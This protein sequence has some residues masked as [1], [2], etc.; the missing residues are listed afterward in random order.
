MRP[1]LDPVFKKTAMALLLSIG[2][3]SSLM[4]ADA[5]KQADKSPTPAVAAPARSGAQ[6]PGYYRMKVGTYEVTAL[7]DGTFEFHSE[8][9][10]NLDQEEIDRLLAQHYGKKIPIQSPINGYLIH[11]GDHLVLIDAGAGR[12]F[13]QDGKPDMQGNLVA[14]LKASGYRP[15]QVDTIVVT[16]LHG[17]HT[18][19]LS[20][21]GKAVFPKAKV[22]ANRIDHEYW[23][24]EQTAAAAPV[25]RQIFFTM[26][27]QS[28]RPYLNNNQWT[29]I[30]SGEEIVPGIKAVSAFGHTPGHTAFEITSEGERLLVWGDI[31]HSHA[32]QFSH[33]EVSI[34]YDSDT[35][36]AKST[37][38]EF[39]QKVAEE[40]ELVAGM[41]LPF[42][43]IGH[44]R[45]DDYGKYRWIPVEYSWMK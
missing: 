16:H 15:E 3:S 1:T 34:E 6:S 26:A 30:E 33:P 13:H 2:L 5:D 41:H 11:T 42:P 32:V 8:L 22:Y 12:L 18:G 14:N 17:D 28:T 21:N 10:K 25:E 38:M 35:E 27:M 43:G 44:V 20:A 9:L 29:P 24:S 23:L 45:I 7:F 39:L 31:I 40:D 4:A 36:K 37:R 19:G